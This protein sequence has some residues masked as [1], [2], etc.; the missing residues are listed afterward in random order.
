MVKYIVERKL[1]RIINKYILQNS[2]GNMIKGKQNYLIY[3][4][5]LYRYTHE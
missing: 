4:K 1:N 3:S 2:Y 5:V